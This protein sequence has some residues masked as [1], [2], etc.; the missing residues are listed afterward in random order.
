VIPSSRRDSIS[1]HPDITVALATFDDD[2]TLLARVL[3]AVSA[4][5]L[6][7]PALVVDMSRGDAIEALAATRPRVR[8]VSY[9]ASAGL[10]DSRNRI[11]DL[12]DTRYLLFVDADAVPVPGWAGAM[13]HGFVDDV[14]IVG[15][16]CVPVFPGR[17]PSLFGT[18]PAL[19]LL[20]MFDLGDV[21][22]T[23]PRIMGTSFAVDL[24]RV[25]SRPAFS[26]DL[27]RRPGVLEGGEE[28][29]LC[30]AV[31]AAGWTVRYEPAAIVLHNVRPER[32]SWRWMFRRA[33]VAGAEARKAKGRL[34]PL[35][36]RG[37]AGDYAFLAAIAPAY[38]AGRL[39]G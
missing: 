19:D 9:R 12:T 16:R 31:R 26:L 11:V 24:E 18:A 38:F 10:S 28:I 17:V 22:L 8:Y 4:E 7:S 25:P 14:A 30:N 5:E 20:G 2:P 35:P 1:A 36:R 33:R 27:G 6:E 15:A 39:R 13:R 37:R 21:P 23:V 29:A 34:E 32:A 3:D